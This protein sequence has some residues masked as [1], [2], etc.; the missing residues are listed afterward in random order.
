METS[1]QQ[2]AFQVDEDG[3]SYTTAFLCHVKGK[4]TEINRGQNIDFCPHCGEGID[5][6]HTNTKD[7]TLTD[8]RVDK[9]EYTYLARRFAAQNSMGQHMDGFSRD[10]FDQ[11]EVYEEELDEFEIAFHVGSNGSVVEEMADVMITLFLLAEIMNINIGEAYNRKM[12]YNLGKSPERD[13]NGKIT[14]DSEL[15]KP[16]FDDLFAVAN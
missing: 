1:S 15:E 11:Y 12:N 9:G 10:A 5:T 4:A 3:E 6:V 16:E 7:E 13:K 8:M 14:D 2:H